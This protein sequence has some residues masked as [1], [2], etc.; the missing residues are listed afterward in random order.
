MLKQLHEPQSASFRY[1]KTRFGHNIFQREVVY[2]PTNQMAVT[3]SLPTMQTQTTSSNMNQSAP[4]SR[5]NPVIPKVEG[6][7]QKTT[8]E[9]YS[10]RNL[11]KT[12][13]SSKIVNQEQSG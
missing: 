2:T 7:T 12:G 9:G 10:G 8:N 1:K 6:A 4:I 3:P 5:H 13:T 11:P